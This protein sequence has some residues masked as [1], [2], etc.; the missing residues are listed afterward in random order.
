[1]KLYILIK[2]NLNYVKV[3]QK[4]KIYSERVTYFRV[5]TLWVIFI[6]FLYFFSKCFQLAHN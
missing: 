1:M 5:V 2:Y 3:Q 6:S 4:E